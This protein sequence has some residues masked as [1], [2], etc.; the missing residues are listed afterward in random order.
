M[1]K[2]EKKTKKHVINV[3]YTLH[4]ALSLTDKKRG[5]FLSNGKPLACKYCLLSCSGCTYL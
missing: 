1:L 2:N 3:V 4:K 5:A